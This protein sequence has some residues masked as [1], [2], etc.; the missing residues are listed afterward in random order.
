MSTTTIGFNF[1]V[2]GVL[3]DA[4]SVVLRDPGAAFGVRRKDTLA[5]VVASGTA[6]PRTSLG[7]YSYAF[8]DPA[9]GLAYN[10]WVEAVFS[11]ATYR[12]EKETSQ[13]A[14]AAAVS[15]LTVVDAD[16]LAAMLPALT[17]WPAADAAA[18]AKALERASSEV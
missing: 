7:T 18:K 13:P 6:V 17:A 2:N 9:G 11:G 3:T 16:L 4:T 12:F 10:Y 1:K 15:Y 5:A 14:S 8:T